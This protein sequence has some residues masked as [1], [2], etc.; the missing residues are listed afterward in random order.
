[1]VALLAGALSVTGAEAFFFGSG[2]AALAAGFW[3]ALVLGAGVLAFFAGM[4][5]SKNRQERNR[6]RHTKIAR[7]PPFSGAGPVVFV[8]NIKHERP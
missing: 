6:L 7:I 2:A 8:G 3:A 1:L 4:R 5:T